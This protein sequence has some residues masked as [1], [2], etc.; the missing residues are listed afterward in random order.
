MPL[1]NPGIMDMC[2][3]EEFHME[4]GFRTQTSESCLHWRGL[5]LKS[6]PKANEPEVRPT[7]LRKALALTSKVC[8]S[9]QC[10]SSCSWHW[11]MPRHSASQRDACNRAQ[12]GHQWAGLTFRGLHSFWGLPSCMLYFSCYQHRSTAGCLCWQAHKSLA[13]TTCTPECPEG[14]SILPGPVPHLLNTSG[15]RKFNCANEAEL[16]LFFLKKNYSEKGRE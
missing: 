8:C 15:M 14:D 12:K 5:N 16:H 1:Q 3:T 4:K 2:S 13:A 10:I 9:L 7:L 6:G 11:R